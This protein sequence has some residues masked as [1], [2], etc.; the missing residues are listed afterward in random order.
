[1]TTVVSPP[2][3]PREPAD[4]PHPR[5]GHP[6]Q[7]SSR[8]S[9]TGNQCLRWAI[10]GG[11]VCPF[12]GGNAPQVRRAAQARA[13]ESQVERELRRL[14]GLTATDLPGI[15]DP[16]EMIARCAAESR[17]FVEQLS[18]MVNDL[19]ED[20]STEDHKTGEEH[21]RA[22]L[23]LYERAMDRTIAAS[24]AL[25]KLGYEERQTRIAEQ[26]SD[27]IVAVIRAS[28]AEMNLELTPD[29]VAIVGRQLRAIGGR[30]G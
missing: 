8:S 18:G 19:R 12:H 17:Y 1:M 22:V 11:T 7:C 14:V 25:A 6:R 16:L 29:R 20:I 24:T 21:L 2:A 9:T 15:T 27:L 13:A 26:D 5:Q 10:I 3:E 28:L 23:G 4:S 30:A